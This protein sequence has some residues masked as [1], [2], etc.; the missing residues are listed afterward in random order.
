MISIAVLT[1]SDAGFAGKRE[2]VS[3]ELLKGLLAEIGEVVAYAILPDE[4]SLLE[5]QML[6]WVNQ[7]I[8]MIMTTGGTGLG[9]RD[10]MPEATAA[11]VEKTIPGIAEAMRAASLQKTPFG[12]LSRGVAGVLDK[13]LIIN[14]PGSPKAVADLVP[15]VRPIIPHLLNLLNGNTAH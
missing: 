12:M 14:L 4:K 10:V 5:D 8:Q 3:G 11:I 1:S 7:G 2:D 6:S 15:V 13:T 9:P